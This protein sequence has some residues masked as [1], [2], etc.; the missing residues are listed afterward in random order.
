M[1]WI[2]VHSDVLGSKLRGLWKS[3]G[4]SE[5]EALGV[6]AILWLWARNNASESGE[7]RNTE[8]GDIAKAISHS[9]SKNI[10]PSFVVEA[11]IQEGWIDKIDGTLYIHDWHEWQKYWYAYKKR[12]DADAERQ[13]RNRS[14][15]KET[16]EQ[17]MP[18]ESSEEIPEIPDE[19]DVQKPK[20]KKKKEEPPKTKF[21]EF[22]RMKDSEYETLVEQYGE[23]FVQKCIVVLDNYKGSSGKTYKSDYRAMLVWV[24][25]KVKKEYPALLRTVPMSPE[26]TQSGNSFEEYRNMW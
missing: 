24:I 8:E 9:L 2:A 10:N 6:L 22:V 5:A 11:M 26:A 20:S 7:L 12:K 15:K 3:I 21:A 4:C 13:R 19:P 17:Q 1:D 18:E 23:P 16:E 25:D 14:K